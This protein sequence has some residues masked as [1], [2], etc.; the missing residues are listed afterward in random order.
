[1]R[2]YV[3]LKTELSEKDLFSLPPENIPRAGHAQSR[4]STVAG[5]CVARRKIITN[6]HENVIYLLDDSDIG[7]FEDVNC[8]LGKFFLQ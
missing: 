3:S 5:K 2:F 4:T 1:M 8:V 7:I 6:G